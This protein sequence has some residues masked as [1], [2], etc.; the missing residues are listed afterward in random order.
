VKSIGTQDPTEISFASTL[1]ILDDLSHEETTVMNRI[2]FLQNVSP[3]ES[4]RKAAQEAEIA[5]QH[6]SVEKTYDEG[7]YKAVK[8]YAAKGERLSGEDQKYLEEALRDYKRMGLELAKPQQEKLKELQKTLSSLETEFSKHINDYE[9]EIWV[10]RK[11]LEG[12][13][14]SFISHLKKK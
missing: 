9:D 14:D 3:D 12:L 2:H 11:E 8:A 1:G 10:D 5:W 7:V 6:W 13:D 4:L